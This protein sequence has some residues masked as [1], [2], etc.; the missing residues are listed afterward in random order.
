MATLFHHA[1]KKELTKESVYAISAPLRTLFLSLCLV[2]S[3]RLSMTADGKANRVTLA[4]GS[5]LVKAAA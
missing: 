4:S 1:K 5:G 2:D 3:F